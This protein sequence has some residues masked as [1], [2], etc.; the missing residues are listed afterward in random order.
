MGKAELLETVN[1]PDKSQGRTHCLTV[2]ANDAAALQRLLTSD[3]ASEWLT[4]LKPK[5]NVP[6]LSLITP[7]GS[8]HARPLRGPHP[9]YSDLKGKHVLITGGAA[10]IGL[11]VVRAFVAQGSF[12]T[13]IDKD[14]VALRR[15]EAEIP[16]VHVVEVDVCDE[17]AFVNALAKIK[18]QR[19]G[20]DVLIGNA[21]ADPRYEGLDMTVDQWNRLFQLNV[22]HYFVLC[23]EIVPQMIARGGGAIILTSSHLAWVA[24]PKCIAYNATKAANI[25]LVRSI[26][27]AYGKDMI[28][29][30]SVAPGW[31][32]TERQMASVANAG[33]FEDCRVNSQSYPVSLT[34][35]L[36]ANNYLYLASDA[37]I[38]L[39][40]Q[41]LVCDMGQAKL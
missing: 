31:T 21:G 29:C 11:G 1:W 4:T 18:S 14:P 12:L 25:A 27:E 33:D 38:C 5:L 24:K 26:A 16:M 19:P 10:G 13:V 22:T 15:L 2:V 8:L 32:M 35:E 17:P 41:T 39:Q 20:V 28:R 23:R 40:R 37:S 34:P 30:N 3:A 6:T 36:L 9:T 7:L